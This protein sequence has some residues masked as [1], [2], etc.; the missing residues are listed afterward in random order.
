MLAI[1]GSNAGKHAA[2][3][4]RESDRAKDSR[5]D[6]HVPPS[7]ITNQG[8]TGAHYSQVSIGT[9]PDVALLEIFNFYVDETGRTVGW[10]KLVHV[11]RRWRHIVFAS[12]RRLRLQLRCTG[13]TPVREMLDVWPVL[14]IVISDKGKPVLPPADSEA[15][16][17]ADSNI[18]AALEHHDRVREIDLRC[19]SSPLLERF[20]TMVWEPY[21]ELTSLELRSND[22]SESAPVLP[23]SFV[24][25]SV[26][27]L[28]KLS[29]DSIAFPGLS[30]LLFS[31]SHLVRL[32][33]HRIP[34]SGYISPDA[35]VACLSTTNS[36]ESLTLEFH[37]PRS[38][39]GASQRP[40]PPL[41]RALLP[42]L[43]RFRFYGASE[44]LEDLLAR[45]D[46]PQLNFFCLTFFNQ[47]SF[48]LSQLPRFVSRT[49]KIKGA[50]SSSLILLQ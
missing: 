46:A 23:D 26:P 13:K 2:R 19:V 14:P 22:D 16:W 28:R 40:P 38:R 35:M 11:C 10:H 48:D 31:T 27:R 5:G 34:N 49:K 3:H 25:G 41:T 33:L 42:S 47:L 15:Q 8:R 6:A 32:H 30:T 50:S 12:L 24:G 7:T 4:Q 1:Q 17:G 21:T 29:L 37:S 9:L 36:L 45:V 39:P 18:I 20:A 43:T 44:Y